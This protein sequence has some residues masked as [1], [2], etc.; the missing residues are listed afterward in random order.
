MMP[1]KTMY[2]NFCRTIYRIFVEQ[3]DKDAIIA[4]AQKIKVELD[5]IEKTRPMTLLQ[6]LFSKGFKAMD[7]SDTGKEIVDIWKKELH[8]CRNKISHSFV[9]DV[10]D[11][12]I[13]K[14][15]RNTINEAY[16]SIRLIRLVLSSLPKIKKAIRN[17]EI[18]ISEDL[19]IGNI[20]IY[21]S[22]L[23]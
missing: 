1:T 5:N 10:Y 19:Y 15:Y 7:G 3:L 22:P 4:F 6:Q 9:D 14:K 13:F 16:K 17:S 12:D 21:F 20:N 23:K 18:E 8:E 11:I 2:H